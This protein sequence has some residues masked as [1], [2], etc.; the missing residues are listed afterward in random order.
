MRMTPFPI[1][2][3]LVHSMRA[4]VR[5]PAFLD[6]LKAAWILLGM[7]FLKRASQRGFRPDIDCVHGFRLAGTPT[8]SILNRIVLYR[9]VFEP[10]L[11]RVIAAQVREGDAC[12]DLGANTGYFSLLFARHAGRT[13][14]VLAVEASPGNIGK[15]QENVAQNGWQDRVA[16][17]LAAC[18][19]RSGEVTFYVHRKNDM[20]CRLHMPEPGEAWYWLLKRD[21]WRPIRVPSRT[22]R[23]LVAATPGLAADKVKFV[24]LDI[25]GAEHLVAP[26]VLALCSHPDLIVALEAKA[27]HIAATLAPFEAAGFHAYDLCNDYRWLV[28]TR[29]PAP[30]PVGF[31]ALAARRGM[32][33]V[34]LCRRPLPFAAAANE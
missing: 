26:E 22:L 24:K 8:T 9:G 20:L 7:A 2:F 31:P 30:V 3:A 23:E 4:C 32:V 15:L 19:D 27:P 6:P 33:D 11:S 29:V 16:I 34:L 12:I 25:E 10:T 28:N 14:R 5:W 13:G 21:N 18:S 17:T 1:A